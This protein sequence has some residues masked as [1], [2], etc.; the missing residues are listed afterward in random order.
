MRYRWTW[1][2][3]R[4]LDFDARATP[5]E[6]STT[7]TYV[8]RNGR[9]VLAAIDGPLPNGAGATPADSDFVTF[10]WDPQG[11][12][13]VALTKPGASRHTLL[14]GCSRRSRHTQATQPP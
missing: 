2:D 13:V 14:A 12:R 5:I 7:F 11:N 4:T 6:R 3:G 10:D 9:S 1:P 8:Q